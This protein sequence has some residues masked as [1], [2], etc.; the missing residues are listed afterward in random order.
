MG[1][2]SSSIKD[3]EYTKNVRSIY[4]NEA[5]LGYREAFNILDENGSHLIA[6]K[7]LSKIYESNDDQ[8]DEF[9]FDDEDDQDKKIGYSEF[10]KLVEEET[11]ERPLSKKIENSFAVF[12]RSKNKYISK[13]QIRYLLSS[14]GDKLTEAEVEE[15]MLELNEREENVDYCQLAANLCKKETK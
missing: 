4:L 15:F 1:S 11:K 6:K 5:D 3:D 9:N 7:E 14:I 10:R 2:S 12:D 13:N 8:N